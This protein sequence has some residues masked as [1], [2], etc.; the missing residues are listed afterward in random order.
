MKLN[1]KVHKLIKGEVEERWEEERRGEEVYCMAVKQ[2]EIRKQTRRNKT[3]NKY[4]QKCCNF[5][6]WT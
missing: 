5:V 1:N 4:E 3:N 6:E 2:G